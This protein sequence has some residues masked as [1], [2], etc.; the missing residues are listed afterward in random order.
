MKK[1]NGGVF[2]SSYV[3]YGIYFGV[4]FCEDRIQFLSAAYAELGIKDS[5]IHVA[6]GMFLLCSPYVF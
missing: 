2:P 6:I 5:R 4:I 1:K 3:N